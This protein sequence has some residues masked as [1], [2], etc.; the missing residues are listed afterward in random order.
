MYNRVRQRFALRW[1]WIFR[2]I[3]RFPPVV[4]ITTGADVTELLSEASLAG[5]FYRYFVRSCDY[6][7][8]FV[9]PNSLKNIFKYQIKNVLF[10]RH[11][12]YLPPSVKSVG[13][14]KTGRLR[15]FH[16]SHI[17]FKVN[18]PGSH[19]NSSKG[20]DRF[21]RAFIRALD[22]GLDAECVILDRGPDR[23]EARAI[24]KS[25]KFS[26]RFIWKPHLSRE[27]MLK[28]Y[29]T[30]DVVVDQFDVGVLGGVAI[31]AMAMAKPVLTYLHEQ[32]LNV[33]YAEHPPVL[34]A[35]TEEDIYQQLM[36][37][38]DRNELRQIGIEAKRWVYQNHFWETCCDQF[39]LYYTLL[40]GHQVVDYGWT[41]DPYSE[42]N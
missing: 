38:S 17:D 32:C 25:S 26:D 14:K 2:R 5:L 24:I 28:E 36:R 18:D 9:S 4:N 8:T 19:R 13:S 16:P 15:F 23:H 40:T 1:R 34:T 20:N 37:Y 10:L 29:E 33:V 39:L 22:D 41:K 27:E 42:G 30:A 11:P 12:F 31:E 3:L 21:L 35:H 7:L 6:N